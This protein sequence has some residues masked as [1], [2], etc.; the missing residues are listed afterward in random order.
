MPLL[1]NDQS[2]FTALEGDQWL[3]DAEGQLSVDVLETDRHVVVRTAVAGVKGDD[4]D[5][6]VTQD[7]VTIRGER[8]C[9]D[10]PWLRHAQAHA[11][12]CHWGRF[13]RSVVLPCHIRPDE[14]DA[15]LKDGV[16]TVTMPKARTGNRITI[17]DE[18]EL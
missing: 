1:Q 2:Y 14:T 8:R 9:P 12:E 4:L 6:S 17:I 18:S 5:V 16:L 15:V 13:S 3:A 11:Q 10:N 7:T